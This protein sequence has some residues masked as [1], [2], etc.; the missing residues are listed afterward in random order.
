MSIFG[1]VTYLIGK[2]LLHREKP[3]LDAV[4]AELVVSSRKLQ[5]KLR[6]ENTTYQSPLDRVR[7]GLAL[8]YLQRP[9]YGVWEIAFLLGFS[10]QSAFNHAL[11]RWTGFSPNEHKERSRFNSA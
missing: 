11:K 3:A 5:N 10:E 8:Q 7:K 9:E 2:N 4:A 6:N 1:R